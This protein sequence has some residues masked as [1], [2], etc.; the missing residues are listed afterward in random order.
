[1]PPLKKS[2][3]LAKDG[4]RRWTYVGTSADVHCSACAWAIVSLTL[5]EVCAI[6]ASYVGTEG[7]GLRSSGQ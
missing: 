7:T 6:L 5:F 4:V 1:M 2:D 3:R